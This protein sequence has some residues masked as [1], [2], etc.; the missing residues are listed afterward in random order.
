LLPER[1][2]VLVDDDLLFKDGPTAILG[3]RRGAGASLTVSAGFE[4]LP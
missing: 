3:E 2:P 1:T 4:L